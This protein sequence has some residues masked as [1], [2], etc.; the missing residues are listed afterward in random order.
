MPKT[1]NWTA[2]PKGLPLLVSSLVD[3]LD[4]L[5]QRLVQLDR[6]SMELLRAADTTTIDEPTRQALMRLRHLTA[7]YVSLQGA[8]RATGS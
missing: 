3:E 5:S 2:D 7:A 6:V 4:G 8:V 1:A